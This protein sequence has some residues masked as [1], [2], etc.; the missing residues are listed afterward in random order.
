MADR[1]QALITELEKAA[2]EVVVFFAALTPAQLERPVYTE[3]IQWNVRQ[4]LAHLVTIEKS[5]HWL[6]RNLLD[7]GAGA[8]EDFD[9]DRFNRSQ[10]AKLDHL[11][12][13]EVIDQFRDVRTETIAIVASMT[14]ADLNR[15]GRH[16]FHGHGRLE[17][18]IR[19]AYEHQR[20]HIN[21]VR[22]VLD[23]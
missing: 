2:E 5:M 7:G 15:E 12:L 4:V 21:D 23:G 14:D 10:P 16:P 19:W 13:A 17:R 6:F 3:S 11:A 22:Q 18:F 8:P 20:F 1:R 9:I